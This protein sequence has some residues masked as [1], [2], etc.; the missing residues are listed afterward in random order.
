MAELITASQNTDV[1][2]YV[3]Y[4]LDLTLDGSTASGGVPGWSAWGP[5]LPG[6]N[7]VADNQLTIQTDVDYWQAANNFNTFHVGQQYIVTFELKADVVQSGTAVMRAIIG[8]EENGWH[9]FHIQYFESQ[10]Y[11]AEFQTYAFI[12]TSQYATKNVLLFAFEHLAN[13]FTIRN[14]TISEVDPEKTATVAGVTDL[15]VP[16]GT[17]V[18]LVT[19]V[20]AADET[21]GD[22]T[23]EISVVGTVDSMVPGTYN[24][25][26]EVTNS[27]GVTSTFRR[28]V[29]VPSPTQ[30]DIINLS[31]DETKTTPHV[32]YNLDLT[33]NGT[34]DGGGTVPGWGSWGLGGPYS[35]Q[36]G[37]LTINNTG[38]YFDVSNGNNTFIEN[39]LYIVTFQVRADQVHTGSFRALIGSN[40]PGWDE[41]H[42]QVFENQVNTEWQTFAFIF[43]AKYDT[44]NVL[45]FNSDLF[46]N[47]F[48]IKDIHIVSVD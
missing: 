6:I 21:D 40:E 1:E 3:G 45:I 25:Y 10:P 29:T 22:L 46:A 4:N 47:V 8:S 24:V 12:F 2:P 18:D 5:G 35:V 17:T 36:D 14:I 26:Y 27:L 15:S 28:I 20:T 41:Y 44:M 9:D 33:V 31:N 43:R 11:S 16:W 39:S 7:T 34:T 32:G 42:A 37:V 38:T 30:S 48:Y 19:G 23:S 13:T